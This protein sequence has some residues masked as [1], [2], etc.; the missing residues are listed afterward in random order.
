MSTEANAELARRWIAVWEEGDEAK[1]DDLY[2]PEFEYHM[3]FPGQ[4]AGLA[5]EKQVVRMLHG[6][7][8][9]LRI[10]VDDLI[11]D[12]H[13]AVI[14]WTMPGTHRGPFRGIPP[15]GRP[16]RFTGIDILRIERGKVVARWDEVNNRAAPPYVD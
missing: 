7:F 15:N 11:V 3:R 12:E 14:R 13:N 10:V 1:L 2:A 6:A 9:D 16:I 4:K 5:G 8:P